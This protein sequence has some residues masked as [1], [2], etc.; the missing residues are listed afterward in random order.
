MKLVKQKKEVRRKPFKPE[1]NA[2]LLKVQIIILTTIETIS[3]KKILKQ[4]I[5]NDIQNNCNVMTSDNTNVKYCNLQTVTVAG[6]E[7][8]TVFSHR[9]PHVRA[10]DTDSDRIN[11]AVVS[12]K[13]L[14]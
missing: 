2:F 14:T 4:L 11:D 1:R 8:L 13:T 6:D 7:K 9:T 12:E 10:T 5:S 3:E